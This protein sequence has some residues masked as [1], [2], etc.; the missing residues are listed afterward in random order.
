MSYLFDKKVEVDSP[1]SLFSEVITVERT[2]IF[3]II[4]VKGISRFRDIT[5]VT[6]SGTANSIPGEIVLSTGT[7]SNSTSQLR[8]A[9]RGRY[10]AGYGGNIGQGIR[11]SAN[12]FSS[13]SKAFWGYGAN[14]S[15]GFFFGVDANRIFTEVKRNSVTLEKKYRSDWNKDSVDGTGPSGIDLDL[16]N[17][18]IFQIDY[19]YYGHGDI[20]FNL[21]DQRRSDLKQ[22][23]IPLHVF[24]PINKTSV[25]YPNLNVIQQIEN[26]DQSANL[27]M[28][29]AG[30]QYSVFGPFDPNNRLV[31]QEKIGKGTDGT[32]RPIISA[33]S[34]NTDQD[35]SVAKKIDGF[36]I[37]PST[38]NLFVEVRLNPTVSNTQVFQTATDHTDDETATIFDT[39][40]NTISGGEIIWKGIVSVSVGRANEPGSGAREKDGLFITIPENQTVSI[41]CRTISGGAG[42]VSAIMRIREEW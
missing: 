2:P 16:E 37:V 35:L 28:F 42:T 34:K 6:G 12:T 22:K 41:A 3:E 7:T 32:L 33:K 25:E 9:E 38:E 18:N 31:S 17:G 40:A 19:S 5:A 15:S 13:T 23:K 1:Q 21:I 24:R 30:R 27:A 39:T 20:E 29:V 4:P 14:T 10:M 11:F 36:D 26:G 8:T